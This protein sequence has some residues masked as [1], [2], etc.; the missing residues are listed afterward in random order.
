[1]YTWKYYKLTNKINN[2]MYNTVLAIK[3]ETNTNK[4]C[5]FA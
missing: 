4:L 3:T 1:M 2:K 5:K